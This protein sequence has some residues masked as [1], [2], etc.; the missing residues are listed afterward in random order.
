M[1][2]VET[3]LYAEQQI[4]IAA[5]FDTKLKRRVRKI[6][7]EEHEGILGIM[8]PE[9]EGH[10][11]VLASGLIFDPDGLGV[12]WDAE[13]YVKVYKQVKVIDLLEEE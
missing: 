8:N 7:L 10:S 4:R 11:V 2:K 1:F 3:G 9:E 5:E 13:T 12:V 6:D